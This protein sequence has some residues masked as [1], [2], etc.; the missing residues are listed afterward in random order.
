[1]MFKFNFDI[2]DDDDGVGSDAVV[3]KMT[4]SSPTD[5]HD[6]KKKVT[7]GKDDVTQQLSLSNHMVYELMKLY[8]KA[9]SFQEFIFIANKFGGDIGTR[10]ANDLEGTLDEK[11]ERFLRSFEQY[12][13]KEV[14]R[15]IRDIQ[16]A[17]QD[18][19][20]STEWIH[21]M[22]QKTCSDLE[23]LLILAM[24]DRNIEVVLFTLHHMK[25]D[26]I[27]IKEKERISSLLYHWLGKL[28]QGRDDFDD[29]EEFRMTK[30]S[31]GDMLACIRKY[32][33]MVTSC[34]EDI[35]LK[36]KKRVKLN[37]LDKLRDAIHFKN[38]DDIRNAL[39]VCLCASSTIMENNSKNSNKQTLLSSFDHL[40]LSPQRHHIEMS[41]KNLE[42]F[43]KKY[44]TKESLMKL[45]QYANSRLSPE[46]GEAI[47]QRRPYCQVCGR[48][49]C[50]RLCDKCRVTSYCFD[51]HNNCMSSDQ[52]RHTP[53]CEALLISRAFEMLLNLK[54]FED[55]LC[56]SDRKVSFSLNFTRFCTSPTKDLDWNL[57]FEFSSST[58]E[59]VLATESLT[60]VL[61]VAY[62]LRMANVTECDGTI[63]VHI[64]GAMREQ[65]SNWNLLLDLFPR[66]DRFRLV[67]VGPELDE[68]LKFETSRRLEMF[69]V[70]TTY[71][72]SK[73]CDDADLRVCMNAGIHHY[74]SWIP[75]LK[76][77]LHQTSPFLCTSWSPSEAIQTF[78]RVRDVMSASQQNSSHKSLSLLV[79]PFG[80]CLPIMTPD[81][82]G[83]CVY[84]SGYLLWVD[85]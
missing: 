77:I 26:E 55:V 28:D 29:E 75:T 33:L 57:L 22:E 8:M 21:E 12:D 18:F 46:G 20:V 62:G 80:S 67:F 50:I 34:E 83:E 65:R 45:R 82:H 58:I 25:I 1:M 43:I 49:V 79:N 68:S 54:N 70:S 23:S 36:R 11:N 15:F 74:D 13:E 2:D 24:A 60:F 85:E 59:K 17:F 32:G 19:R 61:T 4:V 56:L 39:E 5:D 44:T 52:D 73:V 47:L 51:R 6:E 38:I 53:R 78:D 14:L 42:I 37:H 84:S 69:N 27:T 64:I 16:D 7:F 76:Y 40:I 35:T 66:V 9:E 30:Q 31:I 41:N 3:M 10:V 72:E 81:N 48:V 71:H 63:C